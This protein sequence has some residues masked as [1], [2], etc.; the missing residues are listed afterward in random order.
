MLSVTSSF[1]AGSS[2]TQQSVDRGLHLE[3]RKGL[4]AR[5][6]RP[7]APYRVTIRGR[8]LGPRSSTKEANNDAGLAAHPS[9]RWAMNANWFQIVMLAYNLNCWLLLFHAGRFGDS[10]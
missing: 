5:P 2:V 7:G 3:C 10:A 6:I 8:G 9:K 1:R 4:Q